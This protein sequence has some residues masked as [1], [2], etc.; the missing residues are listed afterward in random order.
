M[1]IKIKILGSGS[2]NLDENVLHP[3]V[4]MHIVN[5]KT[6]K[7]LAKSDEAAPGV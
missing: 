4:R 3:F 7:Y 1:A 5:M 2:L 6:A